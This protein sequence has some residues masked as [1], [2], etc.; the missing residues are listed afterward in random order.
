MFMRVREVLAALETVAP[1][2]YAFSFDKVGLQVGD[3]EAEVTK[4]VV[5]LDRSRAAVAH[6]REEGAQ[7]LLAHHPLLFSPLNKV[8]ANDHTGR[9]VLELAAAGIAFVAAHTNWDSAQGGVND[10]LADLLNLQQLKPF[11]FAEKVDRLKLV[12]FA[13][14]EAA[15]SLI[16]ALSA[17][18]AGVIGNYERCAFRSEGTG[19]FLGGKGSNPTV[20]EP[21]KVETVPEVR[22]EMVLRGDQQRIVERTLRE[23]HPYQEP[24][25][26]F[27]VSPA[28]PE[29]AAGRVGSLETPLSLADFAAMVETSLDA[30]AWTWGD[31]ARKIRR[32]A[33]VGGAADGEWMAA[34]RAGAD[35]LVT[36]EVKQ[37]I[38]V[39]AAESGFALI[40]A[41]HYATEQPGVV[42]LRDRMAKA[43]TTIDWKLFAPPHGFAGRPQ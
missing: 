10:A 43:C 17:V 32:V 35:V 16:D 41:G 40:A 11:G 38:A 29:Q 2:R 24:A 37:H 1:V 9:T 3:P 19:T 14:A 15:D 42:A 26:D 7:L 5:S 31:P 33:V 12:F 6:A 18:G 22:V 36:G 30:K 28:V 25:Y 23:K 21:G 4:A 13:P 34:Q 27:L 8:L 39:E 20:G